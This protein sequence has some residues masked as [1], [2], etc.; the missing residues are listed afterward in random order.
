MII[1][2]T[3]YPDL[4]GTQFPDEIDTINKVSEPGID[5]IPLLV[6]YSKK[7]EAGDMEG[8]DAILTKN[9]QLRN[10]LIS[11]ALLNQLRDAL[12]A[13]ERYYKNDI[14]EYLSKTTRQIVFS[15]EIPEKQLQDDIWMHITSNSDSI[16]K[17]IMKRCI[18]PDTKAYE[19]IYART[20]P[21]MIIGLS[22]YIKGT[23]V[24]NAL[25]A[26]KLNNKVEADLSVASAKTAENADKLNNKAEAELSVKY[27]T[28]AGSARASNITMS[29]SGTTLNITYS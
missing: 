10:M 13:S 24:N 26:D 16:L 7:Y 12:I 21:E 18:N 3:F 23:K 5:E 11:A 14:H 9:P 4:S 2:S 20:V 28:T 17:I 15:Q 29:S 25:N 19:T 8:A 27:A 6:E 1:I 22:K